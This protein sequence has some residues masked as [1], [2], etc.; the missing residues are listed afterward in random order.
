MPAGADGVPLLTTGVEFALKTARA[1]GADE[2]LIVMTPDKSDISA[3]LG[4]GSRCGISLDYLRISSSGSSPETVAA[5]GPVANGRDI[6]LLFP[7]ILWTP[8]GLAGRL[9][10]LRGNGADVALALVPSTQ[11]E[12][13]DI[14]EMRPSGRISSL[15]VKPG[16]GATGLTWTC[17]RWSPEFTELLVSE[18]PRFRKTLEDEPHIGHFVAFAIDSGWS[19]GGCSAPAGQALDIGTLDDYFRAWENFDAGM[20]EVCG[21]TEP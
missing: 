6:L 12:K 7:D 15:R 2:A 11:G 9:A 18:L 13:V 1:A 16:A 21:R 20:T 4:D 3:Y 5:A 17:A 14:V 19:V 10:G 8:T